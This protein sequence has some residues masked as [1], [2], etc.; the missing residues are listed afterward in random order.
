MGVLLEKF[1]SDLHSYARHSSIPIS[2]YKQVSSTNGDTTTQQLNPF[3][4]YTDFW[5]PLFIDF[6]LDLDHSSY[7]QDK[8]KFIDECKLCYRCDETYLA[9]I[10]EFERTYT[11]KD[12]I[13]WYTCN[14]FIFRLLNRSLRLHDIRGIFKFRFFIADLYEQLKQIYYGYFRNYTYVEDMK[15]KRYRGQR[16]SKFELDNNFTYGTLVS[17]NSFLSTSRDRDVAVRF[18]GIS[19]RRAEIVSV[20]FECDILIEKQNSFEWKPFADL[21]GDQSQFKSEEEECLFMAGAF[22]RIGKTTYCDTDQFYTVKIT[23]IDEDD[24]QIDITKDYQTLKTTTSIE[25]KLIKIGNLLTADQ[26]KSYYCLLQD[27]LGSSLSIRAACHIGLGWTAYKEKKY[28]EAVI[29]QEQALSLLLKAQNND[30]LIQS[31]NCLGAIYTAEKSY[32]KAL[33]CYR[34][35]YNL[36]QTPSIDK[37]SMYNHYHNISSIQIACIYKIMGDIQLAWDMYEKL[38]DHELRY[39]EEFAG[40]IYIFIAEAGIHDSSLSLKQQYLLWSK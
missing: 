25:S 20:V 40:H 17:I 31:Y 9:V 35:A 30:L 13:R 18:A 38:F 6:L 26:A 19:D 29:E 11:P 23:L 15:M 33:E 34:K 24:R 32:P 21:F 7:E 28:S 4:Y 39:S 12:A 37:Y 5:Q 22:F 16:M 2:I 27:E 3:A 8:Q 1:S 36:G 14:T 10:E